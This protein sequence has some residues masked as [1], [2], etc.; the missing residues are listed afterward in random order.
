MTFTRNEVRGTHLVFQKRRFQGFI[1]KLLGEKFTLFNFLGT[2]KISRSLK[3]SVYVND[4]LLINFPEQFVSTS[5]IRK[6]IKIYDLSDKT[7]ETDFRMVLHHSNRCPLGLVSTYLCTYHR[8][9][10]FCSY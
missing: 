7:F 9:E 6:V 5:D 1:S 3:C 2:T 8:T 4:I 10:E